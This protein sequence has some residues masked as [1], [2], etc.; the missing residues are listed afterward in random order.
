MRL[1]DQGAP[2]TAETVVICRHPARR[3]M[4]AQLVPAPCVHSSAVEALLAI[5]RR[6]PR[7]VL[8]NL[9]DVAGAEQAVVSALRRARPDVP[10]Y[11]IVAPEDEPLGRRLVDEGAADYFVVPSDVRRLPSVLGAAP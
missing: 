7:A 1:P 9:E 5:V 10:I 8:V 11:T 4:L 3:A 2:P 6:R